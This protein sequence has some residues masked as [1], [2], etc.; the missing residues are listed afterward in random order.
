MALTLA[1]QHLFIASLVESDKDTLSH[2]YLLN[3][4]H[5]LSF[6][7]LVWCLS[8][9]ISKSQ[10]FIEYLTGKLGPDAVNVSLSK[11]KVLEK[12]AGDQS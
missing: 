2:A 1:S 10:T 8:P 6:K 12:I 5:L 11:D 7:H 3:S 4:I 9:P